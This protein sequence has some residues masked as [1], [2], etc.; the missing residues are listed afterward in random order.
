MKTFTKDSLIVASRQQLVDII[1]EQKKQ[2]DELSN[3][4][5]EVNMQIDWLKRQVFGAKSE[6]FFPSSDLQT[7]LDLG[8]ANQ[9]DIDVIPR[10][11]FL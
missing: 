9:S 8:I 2:N 1:I 6:R 3:K 5:S 4:L 11:P 10:N 7:A